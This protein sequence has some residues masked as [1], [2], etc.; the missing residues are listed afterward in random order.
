MFTPESLRRAE[1]SGELDMDANLLDIRPD[2]A[3]FVVF[4]KSLDRADIVSEV[5]VRLLE[6]YR[7]TKVARDSDPM[8]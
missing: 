6:A 4:L 8:K 3:Q 5:F 2:P 1:E 7:E